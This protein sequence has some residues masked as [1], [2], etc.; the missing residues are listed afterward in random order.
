MKKIIHIPDDPTKPMQFIH[1]DAL[2]GLL[3]QGKATISRASHV[4]PGD[5]A[6]GQN[7]LQWYADMAPSSG[8]VLGPFET[9]QSALDAEV[10]WIN[11]NVLQMPPH[12]NGKRYVFFIDDT[13][14]PN[15]KGG[16][17]PSIVVEGEAGHRPMTGDPA[18]L[19]SPW[20][21]CDLA[22]AQKSAEEKNA[23]MGYTQPQ[24]AKIIL[25]S[26]MAAHQ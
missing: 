5:P 8:P 11:Q 19:Q 26:M 22:K 12:L 21:W 17:I 6:K 4:E 20:Y 23:Q 2:G 10:A 24:V 1:D 14:V 16:Y 18:K 3:Q 15:P 13:Q 25:S 7:P 9:R